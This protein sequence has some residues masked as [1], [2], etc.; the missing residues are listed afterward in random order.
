[1]VCCE[2]W[3]GTEIGKHQWQITSR[4][5]AVE[6]QYTGYPKESLSHGTST[7]DRGPSTWIS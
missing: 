1:M 6:I 4:L 3:Q 7:M 5:M 2:K